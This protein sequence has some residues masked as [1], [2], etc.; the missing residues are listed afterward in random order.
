MVLFQTRWD[1]SS[2]YELV[3]FADVADIVTWAWTS[4]TK[5]TIY[6][7]MRKI[8]LLF[9]ITIFGW[10]GWWLGAH[11]GIMTAYLICFIGSLL[12]VYVGVRIDQN[13]M[14]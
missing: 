8:I 4:V 2:K 1:I 6:N 10:D 5:S 14:N 13:Y 9:S 11:I 12:G 7:N 3:K